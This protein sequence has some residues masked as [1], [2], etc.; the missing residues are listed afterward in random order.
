[1][2]SKTRRSLTFDTVEEVVYQIE[3][4]H[5]FSSLRGGTFW[6]KT[7]S[8]AAATASSLEAA[9]AR[10]K[11]VEHPFSAR[12]N[13]LD[14]RCHASKVEGTVRLILEAG[15][16]YHGVLRQDVEYRSRKHEEPTNLEGIYDVPSTLQGRTKAIEA[17]RQALEKIDSG[18]HAEISNEGRLTLEIGRFFVDLGVPTAEQEASLAELKRL[19]DFLQLT[20]RLLCLVE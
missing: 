5:R 17:V 12:R 7:D 4:Q 14:V 18:M 3:K 9:G 13:E 10:V 6:F 15:G 16:V 1:M 8:V 20:R 11:V 19:E 2:D